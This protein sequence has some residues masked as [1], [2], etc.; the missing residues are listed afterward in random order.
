MDL[1]RLERINST[2]GALAPAQR[3]AVRDCPAA[4]RNLC[5]CAIAASGLSYRPP[6]QRA[7]PDPEAGFER[8][9]CNAKEWL[10]VTLSY[11]CSSAGTPRLME[12]GYRDAMSRRAELAR[13]LRVPE[14][15]AIGTSG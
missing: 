5:D 8:D 14:L 9:W 12:L 13:F 7:A 15:K 10:G 3:K 11:L 1:E 4:H 6:S 2:V